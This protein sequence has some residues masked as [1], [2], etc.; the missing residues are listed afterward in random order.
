MDKYKKYSGYIK[1]T[2]NKQYH[3]QET[4]Q[5]SFEYKTGL[6]CDIVFVLI[7]LYGIYRI[8]IMF[9]GL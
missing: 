4:N 1:Q 2:P 6:V 5:T 9:G 8:L 3:L 7:V